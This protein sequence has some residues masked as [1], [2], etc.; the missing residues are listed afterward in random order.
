MIG[1]HLA[2]AALVHNASVAPTQ[3]IIRNGFVLNHL[4]YPADE[5]SVPHCNPYCP[6]P[7]TVVVLSAGYRSRLILL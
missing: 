5:H 2:G 7:N 4:W 6:L 1:L 3:R